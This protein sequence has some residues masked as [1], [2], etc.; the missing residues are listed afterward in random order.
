MRKRIHCYRKK[1]IQLFCMLLGVAV[2]AGC[3]QPTAPLW[4]SDIT[5]PAIAPSSTAALSSDGYLYQAYRV[6]EVTW[7]RKLD[8]AGNTLW[9]KPILEGEIISAARGLIAMSDGTLLM[10]SRNHATL[11]DGEGEPIW[12]EVITPDNTGITGWS[13]FTQNRIYVGYAG[14]DLAG[15][16]AI[17]GQGNTLW[18]YSIPRDAGMY[19]PSELAVLDSGELFARVFYSGTG[20]VPPRADLYTFDNQGDLVQMRTYH[21]NS[22][23][24]DN[25]NAVFLRE[26]GGRGR[27][28]RLDPAG[29]TLWTYEVHGD[30]HDCAG[31]PNQEVF[32]TYLSYENSDKRE[33][34]A[35]WLRLDGT[36]RLEKRNPADSTTSYS[37]RVYYDGHDQWIIRRSIYRTYAV[38]TPFMINPEYR[39]QR[40][41]VLSNTGARRKAITMRTLSGWEYYC[42]GIPPF[43]CRR[44][45]GVYEYVENVLSTGTL[46]FAAGDRRSL[47]MAE[48]G[49]LHAYRIR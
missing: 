16:V 44:E 22:T 35:V 47:N 41:T 40:L 28:M 19:G 34:V 12:N 31:K 23:L 43:T 39:W 17:D 30:L 36:V 11:L 20:G 10:L 3:N 2:L 6:G 38:V 18:S 15:L 13:R 8:A 14:G 32:C 49:F 26:D 27:V 1:R 46:L 9:Q 37:E 45:D 21:F 24:V 42:G 25:A 48:T 29:N 4:G 33:D 5:E 7:L